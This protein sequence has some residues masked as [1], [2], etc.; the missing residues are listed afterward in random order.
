MSEEELASYV[1]ANLVS[2][3]VG[4]GFDISDIVNQVRSYRNKLIL[5]RSNASAKS[6]NRST[7]GYYREAII[8]KAF[9][10]LGNYVE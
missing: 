10:Q 6:Y 4:G 5:T 7:K 2:Q 9:S 1:K 8:Y 3:G